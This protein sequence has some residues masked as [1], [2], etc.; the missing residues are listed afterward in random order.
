M[1]V[2]ILISFNGLSV[3]FLAAS[4]VQPKS[5]Y[6][7]GIPAAILNYCL[8]VRGDRGERVFEEYSQKFASSNKRLIAT[9]AILYI[10]VTLASIT[11]LILEY[12]Q[13]H[14]IKG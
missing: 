2:T 9:L 5:G 14:G 10:V 7:F 1:C 11:F 4:D 6:Y 8:L 13:R 3:F 12:R